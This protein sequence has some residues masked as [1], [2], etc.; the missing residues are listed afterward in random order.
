MTA[1]A[2][3][4]VRGIR[5]SFGHVRA[6]RDGDLTVHSGEVV[7]V[8]GDNGA[9]KS[10]F[11]SC[12]AGALRPDEGTIAI[13]GVDL[14][15]GSIHGAMDA[16]IATVYQDL[17]VAPDLSVAENIFLSTEPRRRGILGWL[18]FID[19]QAMRRDATAL[20]SELGIS[21]LGDVSASTGSL[22]GGQRQV[23]AVAR[24]VA[25][26]GKLVILD[27]PTAA[28]GAKQS[29]IVLD[30]IEATRR[31]GLGVILISHDLPRV[32]EIADRIVVM[33][34]GRAV[35]DVRPVGMSVSEIVALMLG[36]NERKEA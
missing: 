16:G 28:L 10:T 15:L 8:V 29:R 9:G 34:F 2:L 11:I 31:R 19:K 14:E 13:D 7:A 18:G 1:P 6:V 33:R 4:E 20:M 3:L 27:E 21:T 30:T 17:A 35:A 5:K 24:A 23:V 12:I 26:A 25:R 32:L 36:E 22:S